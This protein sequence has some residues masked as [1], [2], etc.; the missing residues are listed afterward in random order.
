[1]QMMAM[2]EAEVARRYVAYTHTI[3]TDYRSICRI[4]H[5]SISKNKSRYFGEVKLPTTDGAALE[6]YFG[7]RVVRVS[8][9][10]PQIPMTLSMKCHQKYNLH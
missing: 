3:D 7:P 1:M 2:E 6:V 4:S 9:K 5:I 8:S 10:I